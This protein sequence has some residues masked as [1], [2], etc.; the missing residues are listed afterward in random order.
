MRPG[1]SSLVLLSL[2]VAS[3]GE[4][5]CSAPTPPELAAKPV[6]PI[7]PVKPPCADKPMADGCLGT[8]AF[9]YNDA[10]RAY[11][12]RIPA[13]QTAANA[14]VAKLNA[15]VQAS[16]EYARCEAESLR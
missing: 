1:L 7:P 12:A 10:I 11:N 2:C 16:G 5:A 13:Y 4:A 9:S 15:Y 14:Y 3:G 8:E 6:K